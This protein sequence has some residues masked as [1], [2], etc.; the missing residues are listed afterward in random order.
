M[1]PSSHLS[2]IYREPPW[3]IGTSMPVHVNE[4]YFNAIALQGDLGKDALRAAVQNLKIIPR[5]DKGLRFWVVLA[6]VKV[7]FILS[8]VI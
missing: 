8:E 6:D 5:L 7:W 1:C 4:G 2:S 3:Q